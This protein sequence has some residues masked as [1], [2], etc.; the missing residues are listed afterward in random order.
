MRFVIP[1]VAGLV[2]AA[3]RQNPEDAAVSDPT[4]PP[5]AALAA[6][7]SSLY[8][9]LQ[10]LDRELSGAMRGNREGTAKNT[11]R[12]AKITPYDTAIF[13]LNAVL[14]TT[15]KPANMTAIAT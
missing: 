12:N 15:T 10:E 9:G 8:E 5:A 1:I 14:S 4:P 2:L 11:A 7:H 3:C 6:Q 13:P